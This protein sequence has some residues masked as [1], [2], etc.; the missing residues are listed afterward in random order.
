MNADQRYLELKINI[1]MDYQEMFI[2]ELTDLDFDGFEQYDTYLLAY[3]PA[4]RFSDVSRE[5]IEKLIAVQ[6][7]PCSFESERIYEPQNWNEEWEK[8]IEPM[9][10]G[11][12]FIR[13]TWKPV[14]TPD[15]CYLLE[16]DPK[17]AFG[18]GYHETTRLML[19]MLS[20]CINTGMKVLDVG[21]GTGVLAIA[22]LK[23]GAE[24]A[25]GFDIDEWSYVN[26]TENALLNE[27]SDRF[28]IK[29]GSFETIPAEIHF[30]IILANVNRN[31]LLS[32]SRQIVNSLNDGGVLVLS[33]LLDVDEEA[34]L[35]CEEYA[36]LNLI[37]R[38]QENEWIS[39]RFE[40]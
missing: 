3:V 6:P 39:L 4:N 7:V 5:E 25:F 16:I 34:I 32:T 9:T 14:P 28:D 12:F 37:D 18:T 19:R 10:V 1:P 35:D 40:R 29:E 38:M 8:T 27:V 20:K 15:G 22:A 26:A 13:P 11:E 17:M 24:Y 36:S 31:M 2:S 33:G 23:L 21:T 30:D